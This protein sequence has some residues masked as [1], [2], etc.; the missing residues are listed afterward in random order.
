MKKFIF[1]FCVFLLLLSLCII[2]SWQN[3]DEEKIEVNIT[4]TDFQYD[5]AICDRYF[6]LIEC[7]LERDTNVNWTLEMRQEFRDYIKE[8][9]EERKLLTEKEL[10]KKCKD[11][12]EDFGRWLDDRKLNSFGCLPEVS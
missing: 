4:D 12:L 1:F 11:A 2:V 10:Y 6:E 3:N 8:I 9:Q 5:V 7:I